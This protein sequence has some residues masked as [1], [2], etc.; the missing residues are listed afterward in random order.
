VNPPVVWVPV[1]GTLSLR[2]EFNR[3]LY[4]SAAK[5]SLLYGMAGTGTAIT[6]EIRQARYWML[7]IPQADFV[8]YL[9]TG[10]AHLEGQLERGAGGYIHW[11]L[12]ATF[13][14][15]VSRRQVT[16]LFPTAHSEPTRSSAAR[17]YV[18]KE[19]TSIKDTYFQ[20]GELPI[21]RN[22]KQDWDFIFA[23]AVAGNFDVI[24][25]QIRFQSY[26]TIRA[27]SSDHQTPVGMVR[28]SNV[29]WGPTGSGKSRR[30]WEEAG[31]DAYSKDPRTKFWDGYT[32]Q[33][34]V[35]ID[36]FRGSIDISHVLRWL[37]RYPVRVEI[38]GSSVCLCAKKFWFT[39]NLPPRLW[40]PELD[41]QTF[42]ALNRR[43]IV[44]E[45]F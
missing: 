43:L 37:D 42:D 4:K 5:V 27:I 17:A 18:F 14:R 19:E 10:V 41:G 29:F 28:T 24:P 2:D 20:L 40:Y 21:R 33:E 1:T 32:G 25:A 12:V 34:N 39:S 45:F 38:K 23:S 8:P 26:R 31:L 9:A 22:N 30:A 35:V 44:E 7:T 36:E 6:A 13:S 16:E 11:Q 15:K 3:F